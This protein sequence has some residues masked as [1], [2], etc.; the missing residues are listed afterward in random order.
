MY[1]LDDAREDMMS[2]FCPNCRDYKGMTFDEDL[3]ETICV[4]CS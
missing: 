4:F 1:T 2:T 3:G